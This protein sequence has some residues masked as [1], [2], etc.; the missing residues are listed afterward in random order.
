MMVTNLFEFGKQ[1]FIMGELHLKLI[2]CKLLL[3]MLDID[4]FEYECDE[5]YPN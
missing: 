1:E 3:M 4:F 2:L 5:L